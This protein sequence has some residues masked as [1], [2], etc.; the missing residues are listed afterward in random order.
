MISLESIFTQLL[1]IAGVC[2]SLY[3]LTQKNDMSLRKLACISA[4]LMSTYNFMNGAATIAALQ[5]TVV[6]RHCFAI[7]AEGRE[8]ALKNGFF[9]FCVLSCVAATYL[10]YKGPFSLLLMGG[11][12]ISTYASFYWGKARL[13][14]GLG[15]TQFIFLLAAIHYGLLWQGVS[16]LIALAGALFGAW[17]SAGRPMPADVMLARRKLSI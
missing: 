13:R 14:L 6:V 9:S 10:T 16:S 3:G 1:G 12:L 7:W 15:T 2:V 17:N 5:L 4:V 11:S 8:G